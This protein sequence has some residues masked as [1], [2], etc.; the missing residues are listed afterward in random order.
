M[1]IESERRIKSL[2]LYHSTRAPVGMTL[3]GGTAAVEG[4]HCA[5]EDAADFA[6]QVR[7]AGQEIAY[8]VR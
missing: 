5:D 7:V 4:L 2:Y 6:A 3:D 8:A 1:R